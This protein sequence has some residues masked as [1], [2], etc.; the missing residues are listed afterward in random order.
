MSQASLF[1]CPVMAQYLLWVPPRMM[2]PVLNPVMC[3]SMSEIVLVLG[4][5]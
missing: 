2:G 1:H 4:L 5:S 3:V